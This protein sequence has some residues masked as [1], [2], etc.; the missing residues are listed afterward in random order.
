MSLI[1]SAN[2]AVLTCVGGGHRLVV[3]ECVAS[4]ALLCLGWL[5][6]RY[7]EGNWLQGEGEFGLSCRMFLLLTKAIRSVVQEWF[8]LVRAWPH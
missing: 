3:G 1:A 2:G 5:E 6:H 4:Q 7:S 8:R